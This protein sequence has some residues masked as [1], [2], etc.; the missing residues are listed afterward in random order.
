MALQKTKDGRRIMWMAHESAPKNFTGGRRHD[1][2]S[3]KW[4]ADRVAACQ[5]ALQFARRG[6]RPDG[7]CL[8]DPDRGLKPAGIDLFDISVPETPKLIFPFRPLRT[9]FARVHAV[10]FVDGEYVHMASGA[11]ILNRHN[12]LDD[13]FYQIVDV[14]DPK[15]PKEAGRW[16][17]PGTGKGD[18]EP[19]PSACKRNSTTVFAPT[20]P[21]SSAAA[22]SRLLRLIDGGAVILDIAD[23]ARRKM[24][25]NWRYS[26][27]SM[28][29]A[30]PC[31]RCSRAT[32]WW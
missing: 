9:A 14:R 25:A 1:P 30:T 4:C 21:T 3:R 2:P 13:Q 5:G 10:W 7:G 15:N 12:P 28:A 16:W 22:R 23:K 6:G 8:S 26:R 17:Y 27:H 32:S 29:F 24:V 20:T 31:C 18:S 11:P 19:H